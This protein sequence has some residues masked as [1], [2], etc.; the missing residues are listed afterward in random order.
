MMH[1]H[2]TID[3]RIDMIETY[4]TK[5]IGQETWDKRPESR[6]MS[7]DRAKDIGQETQD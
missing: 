7:T 6:D 2:E 5:D 4:V 1:A 3:M